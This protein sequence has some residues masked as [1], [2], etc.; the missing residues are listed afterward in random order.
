MLYTYQKLCFFLFKAER[1]EIELKKDWIRHCTQFFLYKIHVPH[2]FIHLFTRTFI[3]AFVLY[4]YVLLKI[5]Q[6]HNHFQNPFLLILTLVNKYLDISYCFY[7]LI[8]FSLIVSN[9]NNIN[10][11]KY[12]QRCHSNVLF[13]QGDLKQEK[14]KL[15]K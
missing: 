13:L 1:L 4:I 8:Y 7:C 2:P 5:Q 9:Q 12:L 10:T 3:C 11:N 6:N 15:K 14:E